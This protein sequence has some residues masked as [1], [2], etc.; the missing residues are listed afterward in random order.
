RGEEAR[1]TLLNDCPEWHQ[2]PLATIRT[3]EIQHLLER[4]RDGDD[5]LGLRPR[6]CRTCCTYASAR[7]SSGAPSHRSARSSCRR[8]WG[9]TSHLPMPSGAN[10]LGSKA[11]LLTMRS[12]H[13]GRRPTSSAAL[14]VDI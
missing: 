10:C 9:S 1:R 7:S 12:R 14:T 13:C 2:R 11:R 5:E 3:T 6:K 4:V 8:C